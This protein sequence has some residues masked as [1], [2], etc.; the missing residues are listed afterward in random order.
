MRRGPKK[1][2][3]CLQPPNEMPQ[4]SIAALRV[5]P[6]RVHVYDRP[7]VLVETRQYTVQTIVSSHMDVERYIMHCYSHLP[8]LG[9]NLHIVQH[10][11]VGLEL[12]SSHHERLRLTTLGESRASDA[13]TRHSSVRTRG[14]SKEIALRY[15]ISSRLFR[16]TFPHLR[17]ILLLLWRVPSYIVASFPRSRVNFVGDLRRLVVSNTTTVVRPSKT[18]S[19]WSRT[20]HVSA[21]QRYAARVRRRTISR[22]TRGRPLM[23]KDNS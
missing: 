18:V 2:R 13:N 6:A 1:S 19:L 3:E 16:F 7:P 17:V 20:L 9:L 21:P 10:N 8:S 5:L 23:M 15:E 4:L 14:E 22:K 11:E 12:P